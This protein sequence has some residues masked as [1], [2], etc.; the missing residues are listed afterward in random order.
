MFK[1]LPKDY[2][3]IFI[4]AAVYFLTAKIGLSF[5]AVSGFATLVWP[6]AGIA[7]AALLIF[8][9]RLWPGI[10]LG[11]T[12]VNFLTGAP[13]PVALGMGIGNTLETVIAVFLLQRF[14]KF[15][16]SLEK[17][18]D[19]IGLIVFGAIISPLVAA[20]IGA[21]SLFLGGRIEAVDFF[22]TWSAW[23]VG[24]IMGILIITPL[25]LAWKELPNFKLGWK[26]ILEGNVIIF[27]LL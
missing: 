26:Q 10:F 18:S 25:L 17:L 24:D 6:P 27:L 22:Q 23:W 3:K 9:I 2:I 5:D 13:I 14:V 12:L 4:L 21:G 8:G 19:A 20:T 1:L 7:L 11:A 15:N 16:A